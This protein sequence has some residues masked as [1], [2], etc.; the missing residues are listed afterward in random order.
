MV[1]FSD[2]LTPD[3]LP[4]PWMLAPDSLGLESA[5][6]L[7]S[8]L[9]VPSGQPDLVWE[10]IRDSTTGTLVYLRIRQLD[11]G[12]FV[13]TS[14][15]ARS[16]DGRAALKGSALRSLPLS[17]IEVRLTA[18][19]S[20][21]QSILR[22]TFESVGDDGDP[23]EAPAPPGRNDGSDRFFARVAL[24]WLHFQHEGSDGPTEA[25]REHLDISS[26]TA[27]RWV[28]EA[29][30]RGFLRRS[31]VGTSGRRPKKKVENNGND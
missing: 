31:D 20:A 6:Q 19:I 5:E 17:T 13:I 22:A 16:E 29:R 4:T 28:A 10:A 25:M 24:I 12:S 7:E 27:Q 30:K 14:Y 15:T 9:G 26:A 8:V 21:A 3:D 11:D 23:Y 18:R 1:R 2:T